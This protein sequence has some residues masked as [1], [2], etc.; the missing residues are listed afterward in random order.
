MT[1]T[2]A[3]NTCMKMQH[4]KMLTNDTFHRLGCI[5]DVVHQIKLKP[6][7]K[8]VIHPQQNVPMEIRSK[9]KELEQME[10]LDVTEQVS[11][12]TD[13]VNSMLTVAKKN[14]QLCICIDPRDLNKAIKHEHYQM[15]AIEKK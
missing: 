12:P 11:E 13:W 1:N 8:P 15:R 10:I 4:I 9:V 7:C 14:E 6:D 5:T 3:L 2:L